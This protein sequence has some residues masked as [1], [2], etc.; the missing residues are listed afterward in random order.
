MEQFWIDDEGGLYINAEHQM[1]N[2]VQNKI[3]KSFSPLTKKEFTKLLT[4]R[5]DDGV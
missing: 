4:K 5:I 3:I 1:K 2:L